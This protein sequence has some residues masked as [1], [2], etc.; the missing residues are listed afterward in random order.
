MA[1]TYRYR[2]GETNP[3]SVLFSTSFPIE[4]GDLLFIADATTDVDGD[5][6]VAGTVY[7]ASA[8]KWNTDEATT[9]ADFCA[10]FIG[11]AGQAAPNAT[12][13]GVKDN[14]VRIDTGGVFE[15]DAESATYTAGQLVG[16]AKDTG[17]DLLDQTLEAVSA[18]AQAI[19][20]VV[21]TT[22]ANSTKVKVRIFPK[23]A[24]ILS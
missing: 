5:A 17:N 11:V 13:Y 19:G 22:A 14:K 10:E 16:P 8:R 18:E 1:N 2:H 3:I 24:L 21:E 4:L 15:F 23:K 7:P 9:R 12:A 6:G 20:R